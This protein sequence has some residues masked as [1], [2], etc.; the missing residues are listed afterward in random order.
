MSI[1]KSGL[2]CLSLAFAALLNLAHSNLVSAQTDQ[3]PVYTSN[4]NFYDFLPQAFGDVPDFLA[5]AD[6]RDHPK[7][8]LEIGLLSAGLIYYDQDI[9][10]G[11]QDIAKQWNLV[12]AKDSGTRSRL[13]YRS[14]VS[15][16]DLDLRLPKGLNSYFY[17]IGDGLSTFSVIAGLCTYAGFSQDSRAWNTASQIMESTVLT[18]LFIIT[19]KYSFGRESP[20]QRTRDG[21]DWNPMPPPMTYLRHVSSYDAFPSGHVATA[22]STFAILAAN[23]VDKP[24]IT[25]VAYG[26]V[27]L[28]MFAM[29]NN[30]VHWAGDYPLGIAIGYTA[31]QTVIQKRVPKAK[32]HS[33]QSDKNEMHILPFVNRDGMGFVMN[34]KLS[35]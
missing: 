16:F 21:G 5:N 8:Y 18:G 31:A 2:S 14:R 15:G 11:S 33:S 26:A 28:L 3:I 17:F 4:P 19:S 35:T 34:M 6:V 29:L 32:T 24:W 25:P 1:K 12:S 13:L 23:Y 27:G 22:T 7:A 10:I 30:G 20:N 9:L